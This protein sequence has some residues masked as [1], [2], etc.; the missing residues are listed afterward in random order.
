M[1]NEDYTEKFLKAQ[2]RIKFLLQRVPSGIQNWSYQRSV[3]YKK[4][5][6]SIEN[7]MKLKPSSRHIDY[8]KMQNAQTRL[9]DYYK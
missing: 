8:L 4:F 7:L 5:V 9:E 6:K 3:D 2:D 1:S